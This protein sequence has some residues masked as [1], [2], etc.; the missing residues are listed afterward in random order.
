MQG[1]DFSPSESGF[2]LEGRTW[3]DYQ[4]SVNRF[5]LALLLFLIQAAIPLFADGKIYW[6]KVNAK[7]PYQRALI[8]FDEGK[9]T[10]LLQSK[11]EIPGDPGKHTL[12]WV[13]P[14]P[15]VPEVGSM[16]AA[17]ADQLFQHLS[18]YSRP[19]VTDLTL[20][21][22]LSVAGLCA[23]IA[24]IA[25][26]ASFFRRFTAHKSF[27]RNLAGAALSI[28]AM[29]ILIIP[30]TISQSKGVS[31]IEIVKSSKVG[32]YE[33]KVVRADSAENLLQW[34]RENSF[35]FDPKDAKAI[36]SHIDRKWCFVTAKV[37]A[38]ISS[39]NR[40]HISRKLL[41]PLILTFPTPRPVYPT[42]LTATGGHSTEIL[43]Y[44][45][46]KGPMKTEAPLTLRYRDSRDLTRIWPELC[47]VE[48]EEQFES[49]P[50]GLG[51]LTK[52]KSI[53]TPE[54]MEKDIEFIPDPGAQP[55][56][57]HVYRW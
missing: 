27:L 35:S 1:A 12:G 48:P 56:R 26:A 55:Y 14:V 52:F 15:A 53:L 21:T 39:A 5:G 16:N 11:Y 22:A 44:L 46:S 3:P 20:I 38:S 10:L 33:T 17:G 24:F 34:L 19:E 9:E 42:A 40:A 8:L 36:Q 37:D 51:Y 50:Q 4:G 6:E 31:G 45:A 7:I 25:L 29:V 13:V 32:I 23:S 57:D 18:L 54:E 28:L 43:I 41:A 2:R 49:M 47:G 30:L